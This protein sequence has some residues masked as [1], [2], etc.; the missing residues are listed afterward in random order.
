MLSRRDWLSLALAAPAPP[1]L[2]QPPKGPL[3][4]PDITEIPLDPP[5]PSSELPA[6]LSGAQWKVSYFHDFADSSLVFSDFVSPSPDFALAAGVIDGNRRGKPKELGL[7]SRD[8][9]ATWNEIK[10]PRAPALLFALDASHVWLAST[11]RLYFSAD[12]G[13]KWSRLSFPKQMARVCFTSPLN[14]FAYGRGKTFYRTTDGGRRWS[15]VAESQK[16]RLTDEFTFLRTMQCHDG[17]I[18]ILAGNSQP[19]DIDP[20]ERPA[21]MTP[22]RALARRPR[23]ATF[24]MLSTTDGGA[25]WKPSVTPAVGTVLRMK[26]QADLSAALFDYGEGFALPSE[27]YLSDYKTGKNQSLFRRK[28]LRVTDFLFHGAQGYLLSAIEPFGTLPGAGL[29]GRL[30]ILYSPDGDQWFQ[31]PVDYRAQGPGAILSA[32]GDRCFAV[33]VNGM[34]L[35]LAS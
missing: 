16:L 17:R 21:W 27:V 10:L 33:L 3:E 26:V 29:P 4:A 18:G 25:T 8:G 11:G 32:A 28:A 15:P 12:Q 31:T 30:R 34:I 5:R 9:G 35:R 7:V 13:R 24:A 20:D 23:P 2:A 6:P 14:G 22:E 19:P 1:A